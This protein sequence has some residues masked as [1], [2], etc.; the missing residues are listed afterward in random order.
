YVLSIKRKKKR[1]AVDFKAEGGRRILHALAARADVLV[2][3][4][5]PGTLDAIG[6]GYAD[7]S[8]RHPQLVYV[9]ISGF[10]QNGPRRAEPGSD[11]VAK[12]GGGR[13]SI[14]GTAEGPAVR[15]GVAIADIASGMFAFQGLLLALL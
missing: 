13:R 2:E 15:L 3:N 14:T 12:G 5:R 1:V 10:G 6:L 8:Q 4:F 9:S 11:A 7:V